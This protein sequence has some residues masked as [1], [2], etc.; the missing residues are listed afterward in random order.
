[1]K[2]SK[3]SPFESSDLLYSYLLNLLTDL[4]E[5]YTSTIYRVSVIHFLD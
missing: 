4:I 5:N 2:M 3:N 1:M